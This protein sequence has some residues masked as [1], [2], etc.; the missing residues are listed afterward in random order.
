MNVVY[1][2]LIRTLLSTAI[3]FLDALINGTEKPPD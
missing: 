1:L 2:R 3:G